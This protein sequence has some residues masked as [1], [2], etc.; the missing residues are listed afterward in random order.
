[1]APSLLMKNLIKL[2]IVT[3]VLGG[4]AFVAAP[5]VD[6]GVSFGFSVG[7]P[8]W[9]VSVGH[10]PAYRY[11]GPRYRPAPVV[12]RPA[13]RVRTTTVAYGGR[14]GGVVVKQKSYRPYRPYRRGRVV[15]W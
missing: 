7:G 13:P 4:S 5:K 11:Y 10:T 15:V 8:R 14:R 9:G 1:M 2:A 6:A 3:L 12:V